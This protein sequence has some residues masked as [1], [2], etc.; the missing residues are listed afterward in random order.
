MEGGVPKHLQLFDATRAV[1]ERGVGIAKSMKLFF[2]GLLAVLP[3]LGLVLAAPVIQTLEGQQFY[4][5]VMLT[6]FIL[7]LLSAALFAYS[8][9]VFSTKVQQCAAYKSL[10]PVLRLLPEK[11][12]SIYI[13]SPSLG[14]TLVAGTAVQEF[15]LEFPSHPN[16]LAYYY[17][18]VVCAGMGPYVKR[19][20]FF[21]L[22]VRMSLPLKNGKPGRFERVGTI[23]LPHW[24]FSG[25]TEDLQGIL[26][27]RVG[28]SDLELIDEDPEPSRIEFMLDQALV[29]LSLKKGA[30]AQVGKAIEK[31]FELEA[32]LK[33]AAITE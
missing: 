15:A 27:K 4:S 19:T 10:K 24:G 31:A 28:F 11:P 22:R 12:T 6:P 17:D 18:G 21:G 23:Y 7:L 3:V 29:V 16:K 13:A 20:A 33:E 1:D 8:N 30:Y 26:N 5:A 14:E 25:E 32:L 2:Y 9:K